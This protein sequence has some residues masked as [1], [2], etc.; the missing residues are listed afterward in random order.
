MEVISR[1]GCAI[2]T[3]Q[4]AYPDRKAEGKAYLRQLALYDD[5]YIPSLARIA[6]MINRQGAI[7]IQQI[8][9]GGRYGGIEL[10][11][12]IQPSNV[13]Q[14]LKHFRPPRE[15]KSTRLNSSHSQISYA[16]FCLKK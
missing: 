16:V 1:T 11:Y 9:H 3:N 13:K 5:K 10:D 4:G 7:S 14:T 2:I 6:E 12:C 15:R 8:L